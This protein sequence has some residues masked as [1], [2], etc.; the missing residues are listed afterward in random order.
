MFKEILNL[1]TSFFPLISFFD[2]FFELQDFIDPM[3]LAFVHNAKSFGSAIIFFFYFFF[4]A[5]LDGLTKLFVK[6][7]TFIKLD[8]CDLLQTH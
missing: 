7:F 3:L 6:F 1:A 4:A 5:N 8:E 2:V